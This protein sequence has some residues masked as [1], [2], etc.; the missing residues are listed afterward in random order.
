M[1]DNG[2]IEQLQMG[3]LGITQTEFKTIQ[4]KAGTGNGKAIGE[5]E[6]KGVRLQV[7]P[8]IRN[9]NDLQSAASGVI[10]YG[11]SKSQDVQ[12]VVTHGANRTPEINITPLIPCT[13]LNQVWVRFWDG[14]NETIRNVQV[15]VYK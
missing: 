5:G 3:I 14:G 9:S 1:C 11:D 13:N 6:C 8:Y 12:L 4:V 2:F 15:L 7:N 10:S